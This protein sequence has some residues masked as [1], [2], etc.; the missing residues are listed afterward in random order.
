[1]ETKIEQ[2]KY[3][4]ALKLARESDNIE[5]FQRLENFDVDNPKDLLERVKSGAIRLT[6]L[7]ITRENGENCRTVLQLSDGEID[8]DGTVCSTYNWDGEDGD[9]VIDFRPCFTCS[10]IK[11]CIVTQYARATAKGE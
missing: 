8:Y 1:M 9:E 2:R 11:D 5:A 4:T 10:Y 3:E 7:A 6:G